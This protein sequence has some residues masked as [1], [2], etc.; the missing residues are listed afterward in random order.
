MDLTGPNLELAFKGFQ[1]VYRDS[2][3]RTP[4]HH[5]RVAMT[6]PSSARD[7]TYGWFGQ[8][9]NLREWVGPRHVHSLSTSSFTILN[10]T[11]ES[12]VEVPRN[13]ISDDRLGIFKPMFAEMGVTARTH[14]DE[15]LFSLL[16]D[17]FT[18]E[19]YDGQ[20]FFDA[21]HPVVDA[22]GDTVSVSNTDGGGGA[23]W[24]LLD[25]SRAVRPLI[26]QVREDYEFQRR[27]RPED[28]DVFFN[29]QFLYGIRARVNAG[30]GLWQLAYGPRQTLNA[31][32]YQTARAAMMSFRADGGRPLGVRPDVL[33]VPPSLEGAARKIL[34]SE[35]G[36]G[37]M[38]NEWKGAAELIVS[39]FL[40][41]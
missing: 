34:N 39:P 21:D 16:K 32:A 25:T 29:D 5:E 23:P 15:L 8:F 26:W 19:C 24:F 12:T 31:A 33:V 4:V 11:F 27:D 30:F 38:T 10:R 3:D 41:D 28:D 20:Y 14:P 17:G 1:T 37:G 22:E 2:Y 18:S 7:E 35:L 40:A 9:P 13:T 36:D 6:V